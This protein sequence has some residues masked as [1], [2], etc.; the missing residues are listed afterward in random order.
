M[1]SS[2]PSTSLPLI[3]PST[4]GM[5]SWLIGGV[6]PSTPRSWHAGLRTDPILYVLRAALG[7]ALLAVGVVL[8]G[9]YLWSLI[10]GSLGS[11]TPWRR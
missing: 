9:V 4:A 10:P 8:M 5:R 1:N 11:R 6:A 3:V 7:V 2:T